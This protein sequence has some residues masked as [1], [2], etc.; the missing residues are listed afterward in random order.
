[1]KCDHLLSNC[2][3]WKIYCDDHTSLSSSLFCQSQH[4][5]KIRGKT[6]SIVHNCSDLTCTKKYALT[7]EPKWVGGGGMGGEV[8][9][10]TRSAPPVIFCLL[11]AC[12]ESKFGTD[13]TIEGA[14]L[15]F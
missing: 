10:A 12:N 8:M 15:M 5:R 13:M 6:S 2:L 4:K 9:W 11:R 14:I 3:N 7:E 1:M